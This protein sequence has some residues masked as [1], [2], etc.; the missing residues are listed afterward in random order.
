MPSAF[1]Q[2]NKLNNSADTNVLPQPH[3]D[4]LISSKID[5]LALDSTLDLAKHSADKILNLP[6]TYLFAS[7]NEFC[8]ALATN[9]A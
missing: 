8:D 5:K 2:N 3:T 9:K 1:D 7:V 6:I 4:D